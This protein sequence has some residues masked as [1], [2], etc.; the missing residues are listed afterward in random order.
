MKRLVSVLAVVVLLSS[1]VAEAATIRVPSEAPTIQDG[2]AAAVD[3]DV[4]LVASGI[5]YETVSLLG[6][7]IALLSEDGAMSTVVR[8][9]DHDFTLRE[10]SPCV[11]TGP[12]GSDIGAFGVGCG[13]TAVEPTS[14]G[15]IKASYR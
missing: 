8:A 3:E 4:V 14:W 13:A 2:V 15:A 10:S 1:A 12:M 7:R 5:Y 11:G 6:K 9:I